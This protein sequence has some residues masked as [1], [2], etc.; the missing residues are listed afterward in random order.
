MERHLFE[1]IILPNSIKSISSDA[2]FE[3]DVKSLIIHKSKDS[4]S[5]S[6]WGASGGNK[7]VTWDE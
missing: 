2:F 5:G 6:P 3:A 1:T 7:I 4:I